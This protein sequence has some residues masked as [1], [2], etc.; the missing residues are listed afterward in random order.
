MSNPTFAVELYLNFT[1]AAAN[2]AF[3]LDSATQGKLDT[4]EVGPINSGQSGYV[5]FNDATN[6]LLDSNNLYPSPVWTDVTSSVLQLQI[7]RGHQRRLDRWPAGTLQMKLR[8][9]TAQWDPTNTAGPY[10]G[11][12]KPMRAI[13]V[14]AITPGGTSYT[15]FYGFVDG[16]NVAYGDPTALTTP[17]TVTASDSL[18][19][20]GTTTLSQLE[21]PIGLGEDTGARIKR[22]LSQTALIPSALQ[23]IDTGVSVMNSTTFNNTAL[24]LINDAVDAEVSGAFYASRSG[25]VTFRRRWADM[26]D[27]RSNQS[28]F[29]FVDKNPTGSQERYYEAQLIYDDQRIVNEVEYVAAGSGTNVA[30]IAINQASVNEYVE[31]QVAKTLQLSTDLQASSLA[32]W[33]VWTN[34]IPQSQFIEVQFLQSWVDPHGVGS[35]NYWTQ[36]FSRD[37]GDRVT[38]I[39]TPRGGNTF[40]QDVFVEGVTHTLDTGGQWTTNWYTQ[41]VAA[42][43]NYLIL[44]DSLYGQLTKIYQLGA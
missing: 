3:T 10:Y 21:T 17:I 34:A 2:L 30:Q 20:L 7:I 4:N 29:T 37:I 33:E 24:A 36:L 8:N 11:E 19:L 27:A 32:N 16:W 6:G 39:K 12:L 5:I 14:R 28:Q 31:H 43:S 9:D 23:S 15:I 25:V 41:S 18:K 26:T 44:N 1:P 22:I 13:R 40:Q 42:Y 35:E 38:L